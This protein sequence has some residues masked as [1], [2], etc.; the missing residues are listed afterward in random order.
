LAIPIEEVS[1]EDDASS[2]R[3]CEHFLPIDKSSL[4]FISNNG[5]VIVNDSKHENKYT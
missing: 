5:E 2:G 3:G 4:T 1:T